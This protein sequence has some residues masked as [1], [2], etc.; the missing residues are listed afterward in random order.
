MN[1]DDRKLKFLGDFLCFRFVPDLDVAEQQAAWLG[2]VLTGNQ[3]VDF[4]LRDHEKARKLLSNTIQT[5]LENLEARK[6]RIGVSSGLD[7]RALL[8]ALSD[9]FDM[10]NV[11]AFTYG[12]E[13]NKDYEHAAFLVG[14]VVVN[15]ELHDYYEKAKFNR[16]VLKGNGSEAN[17]V[18]IMGFLGDAL[19]GGHLR[20]KASPPTW[21]AACQTFIGWQTGIKHFFKRGWMPN[22]YDP[23]NSLPAEPW[24]SAG[25]VCFDDQLDLMIRQHQRITMKAGAIDERN[26]GLSRFS[27]LKEANKGTLVPFYTPS[28]ISCFLNTPRELRFE[29]KAYK[30]FLYESYPQCFPDLSTKDPYIIT[31]GAT[32]IELT[33]I[34]KADRDL[35]KRYKMNFEILQKA[36]FDYDFTDFSD[37]IASGDKVAAKFATGLVKAAPRLRKA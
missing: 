7:S 26:L 21:D 6:V 37:M 32:N 13:S 24:L 33:H 35:R 15:H 18:E 22:G 14:N 27:S 9:F 36:G 29:K 8:G 1:A 16:I 10:N 2:K 17:H 34:W 12:H 31:K 5:E 23:R 25:L 3:A 11:F 4:D 20:Q 28:I 30:E 19:S